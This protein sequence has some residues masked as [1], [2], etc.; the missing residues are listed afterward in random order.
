MSTI[1]RSRSSLALRIRDVL[2]RHRSV[3]RLPAAAHGP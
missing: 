1:A 3:V 2:G